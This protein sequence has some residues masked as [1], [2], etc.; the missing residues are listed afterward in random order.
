[1]DAL[2]PASCPGDDGLT[3]QFFTTHLDIV[4]GPMLRGMQEIFESGTM[5]R[6]LCFGL[7]SLILNGG[8]SR[9]L[10]Q[11]RP[12]TLLP[13]V[14]KILAN[15]LAARVPPFLPELIHGSQTA[16]IKDH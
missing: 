2:R 3:R 14:Y 11:W 10:R 4:S 16:F 5:P 12:I 6:S 15:L 7:I 8:D 13:T 9:L 1:M